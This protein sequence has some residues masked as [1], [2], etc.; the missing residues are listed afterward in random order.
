[1]WKDRWENKINRCSSEGRLVRPMANKTTCLCA[2]R[3]HV[4]R[5][6]ASHTPINYSST[7]PLPPPTKLITFV[8]YD[9]ST[10]HL[11]NLTPFPAPQFIT[12]SSNNS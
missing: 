12:S 6:S 4:G 11:M 9:A 1:M 8:N 7:P 10:Q 5:K 2:L 3:P